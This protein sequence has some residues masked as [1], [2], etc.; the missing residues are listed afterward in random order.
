M[1]LNNTVLCKSEDPEP[2]EKT[3]NYLLLLFLLVFIFSLWFIVFICISYFISPS[4]S[5]AIWEYKFQV[6]SSKNAF[7]V[8]FSVRLLLSGTVNCTLD[9]VTKTTIVKTL[10]LDWL[11]KCGHK[12]MESA[13]ENTEKE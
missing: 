7:R 8:D 5:L 10:F 13:T 12:L 6:P 11:A 1:P 3:L 9:R 2:P 4:V